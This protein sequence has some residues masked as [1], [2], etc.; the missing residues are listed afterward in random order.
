M[1]RR[2]LLLP[3][4]IAIGIHVGFFIFGPSRAKPLP[5]HV[6]GK[7][8]IEITL[9]EAQRPERSTQKTFANV[10]AQVTEK[11]IVR[12]KLKPIVKPKSHPEPRLQPEPD[13]EIKPQLKDVPEPQSIP[14]EIIQIHEEISKDNDMDSP[15][16]QP[17]EE[18]EYNMVTDAEGREDMS[19]KIATEIVSSQQSDALR[20]PRPVLLDTDPSYIKCPP[21]PYPSVAR[22]RGVQGTVI[23]RVEVLPD[24]MVGEIEVKRSSG[25][26]VLDRSALKA[27]K[28]W[29]FIP[30][31]RNGVYAKARVNVPVRFELE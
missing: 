29:R 8:T 9:S 17:K 19:A 16:Q 12:Q 31:V 1:L 18:P 6:I 23:L 7:R 13:P 30:A 11:R 27:V 25:F 4:C 3:I 2:E 26:K 10:E 22:R 5:K 28:G 21:P 24:G 20:D 15:K 14:K